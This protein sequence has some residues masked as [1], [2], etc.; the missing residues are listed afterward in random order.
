M[1]S[2]LKKQVLF[3]VV[4]VAILS[5]FSVT[6]AA[7]DGRVEDNNDVGSANLRQNKASNEMKGIP[8]RSNRSRKLSFE[9]IAGYFPHTLVTDHVRVCYHV[10]YLCL[11]VCL[12]VETLLV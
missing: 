3:G 12:L 8:T 2:N 1:L 4:F 5:V 9:S 11:V 7:V 6:S 10:F